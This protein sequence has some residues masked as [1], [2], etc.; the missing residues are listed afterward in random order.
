MKVTRREVLA[1]AASAVCVGLVASWS[2]GDEAAEKAAPPGTWST[3]D[4]SAS[5]E[6]A[7]PRRPVRI[8]A[9]DID[10]DEPVEALGLTAAG[11]I[12]PPP[13]IVQWYTGSV[14][15]GAAGASVIAGHVTSP[16]PDVFHRLG[17]LSEGDVVEVVDADGADREFR[18]TRTAQIDK[19]ALTHDQSVWGDVKDPTLVL[20]TCDEDSPRKGRHLSGNVVVWA[21]PA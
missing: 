1:L 4:P 15:P 20:I 14:V 16:K 19:Q 5:T 10:L 3:P 7:D 18:V 8:R 6:Q 2:P 21:T 12:A 17:E 11:E 13:G 9:A